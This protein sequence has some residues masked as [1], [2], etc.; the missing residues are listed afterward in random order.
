MDKCID[1]GAVVAA[2]MLL[3]IYC[4]A[5]GGCSCTDNADSW[6]PHI[7]RQFQSSFSELL[8]DG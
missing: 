3:G 7:I 1:M 4:S 5:D 2:R 6:S 8:S